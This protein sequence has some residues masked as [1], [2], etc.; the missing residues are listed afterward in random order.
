MS[1]T[2]PIADVRSFWQ[3][4]AVNRPQAPELRGS[5]QYDVAIIGGGF[6][7]LSTARYLAKRGLS[8]AILE[9]NAIGWGC[10]GRNGGV[11]SAKYRI[12]YPEI[13][14][15]HGLEAARRMHALGRETVEHLNELVED[16]GIE[17]ADYRQGG[18][19]LCAHTHSYMRK[20]E[21]EIE[22]MRVNLGDTTNR[23]VSAEEVHAETSS[24][25]F[26]GG[27]LT[28]F[29]GTLHPL[30]LV[31]GMAN[32]VMRD[33]V[34]IYQNS[35]VLKTHQAGGRVVLETPNGTVSARQM[36]IGTDGYNE[37]TPATGGVR[38]AIVPFRSAMIVSEPLEQS[39]AD[40]LFTEGRSYAETRR[41]MRWFRKVDNR[42]MY[43][44]RG[45]FG[46]EDSESAFEALRR[47]MFR[48]FPQLEGK[49]ITHR[50]SGLVALTLDSIPH[51]GRL[52]DKTVYAMGYNGTGVAMS[53]AIG[54]YVAAVVAGEKPDLGL[55]TATPLKQVPMYGVREPAVRMVAGWYQFLDAIG[56]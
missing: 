4:T 35:P 42:L 38:K 11:V 25:D 13:A 19:L 53:S 14:R 43:G 46:K 39:V 7:G 44:G 24:R 29:G 21:K 8:C 37:L 28:S 52:D 18:W 40:S 33:G 49:Q 54:K 50:W 22:W 56:R 17:A 2:L 6:T 26:V 15:I 30:N 32:G 31:F 10:S 16:Y 1:P 27:M 45:A 48:Q 41:M 12:T 51:L 23:L 20:I 55:I 34:S 5:R 3:A 36:V 9:A 47:A